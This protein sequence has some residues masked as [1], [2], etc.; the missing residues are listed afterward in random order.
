MDLT[1]EGPELNI[2]ALNDTKLLYRYR[3]YAAWF[4]VYLRTVYQKHQ[5]LGFI[6]MR[7]GL[8]DMM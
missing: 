3:V 8:S 5:L 2:V 6:E 4:N 7:K 1:S